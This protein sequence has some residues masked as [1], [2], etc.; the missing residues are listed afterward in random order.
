M[1]SLAGPAA[2]LPIDPSFSWSGMSSATS[3]A[4]SGAMP[5]SAPSGGGLSFMRDRIADLSRDRWGAGREMHVVGEHPALI[6]ALERAAR[7]AEADGPVLITGETG[8]GKELF[9]HA[10]YL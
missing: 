6:Q 2:A 8:T 7:F 4:M 3:G 1:S 10:V 9:A 5:M